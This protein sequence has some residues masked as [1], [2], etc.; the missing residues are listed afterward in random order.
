MI[1]A[2]Y[3][4][5]PNCGTRQLARPIFRQVRLASSVLAGHGNMNRGDSEPGKKTKEDRL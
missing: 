5:P 1:T 4:V 3:P 2:P